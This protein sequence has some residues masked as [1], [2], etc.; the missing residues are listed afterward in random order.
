MAAYSTNKFPQW[1]STYEL[2]KS[3]K[4]PKAAKSEAGDHS[5]PPAS[6][7]L[8]HTLLAV[9]RHLSICQSLH[10]SVTPSVHLS[11][12]P[13]V[14]P[15]ICQSLHL[16][17]PPSVHLSVPPS[18]HLSVCPCVPVGDKVPA[19]LRIIQIMSTTLN[20]DQSILTGESLTVVKHADTVPDPD[21]QAVNQDKKNML[22]SV[23]QHHLLTPF[24]VAFLNS[25]SY[26]YICLKGCLKSLVKVICGEA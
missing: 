13:F 4:M 21:N 12:C 9:P 8:S 25:H 17:V 24:L 3:Y 15:S 10:L 1:R 11:V 26:R 14:N 7:S 6:L 2:A 19:D 18:V 22:F 16:S 5:L 23:H 20:V